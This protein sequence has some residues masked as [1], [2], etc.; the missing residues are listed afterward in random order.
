[1][2]LRIFCFFFIKQNRSL[3]TILVLTKLEIFNY[4]CLLFSDLLTLP[5]FVLSMTFP[6][7]TLF[8]TTFGQLRLVEIQKSWHINFMSLFRHALINLA[9]KQFPKIMHYELI[10]VPAPVWAR[11][12]TSIFFIFGAL[13]TQKFF[14]P[15]WE[16]SIM[17]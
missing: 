1:M 8:Q 4:I 14:P 17:S 5:R 6:L 9:K 13:K 11:Q 2:I 3:E 12:K 7:T 15:I 10:S 16:K